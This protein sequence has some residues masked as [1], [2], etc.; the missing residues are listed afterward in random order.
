MPKVKMSRGKFN[1]IQA[2]ADE[3][4]IIAAAAMDQRGSLKK[5]I[6]KMRGQDITNDDLTD[7]KRRVTKVL[8]RL[9]YPR[10]QA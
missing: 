7:F 6:S 1:H 5:S 10:K 9:G 4:G 3:K 2:C 8:T